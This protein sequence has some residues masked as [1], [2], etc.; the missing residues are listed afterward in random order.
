[1]VCYV[2]TRNAATT[3][4]AGAVGLR[5]APGPLELIQRFVNT[6]VGDDDL[7]VDRARTAGWI[8]DAGFGDVGV[9]TGTLGQLRELRG[10]VLLTL[11]AHT[12]EASAEDAARALSPICEQSTLTLTVGAAGPQV[13]GTGSGVAGLIN[14]VLARMAVA[15]I[16]GSWHR[17]KAC[18]EATCRAAFWD[19]TRN[20]SA[21][22]CSSS[23]CGNR[24][25]QREFRQRRR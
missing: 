6:R 5:L 3:T 4:S 23:G 7:F 22:Y 15:A 11:M 17:L 25:R 24:A 12:G 10:A 1:M 9:D 8:A 14:T 16:D 19:A 18:A 20:G 13:T 21:R 2:V